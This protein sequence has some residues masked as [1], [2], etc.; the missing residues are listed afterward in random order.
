MHWSILNTFLGKKKI[1]SISPL[2]ENGVIVSD[3]AEKAEIYIEYFAS[4]C[5]PFTNESELPNSV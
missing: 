5:S 3:Y 2:F 1:P 4:Q